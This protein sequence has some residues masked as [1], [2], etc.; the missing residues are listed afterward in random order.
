MSPIILIVVFLFLLIFGS[1]AAII[2]INSKKNSDGNVSGSVSGI[3]GHTAEAQSFL[4]F[5]CIQDNMIILPNQKFRMVLDCTSINYNL[6]TPAE[7]DQIELSFQRFLNTVACPITMFLQTKTI[8]NRERLELLDKNIEE[9]VSLYPGVKNYAEHYRQDMEH[10]N[11]R[12]GNSHQKKRY[13]IV[14]YDDV[15]MLDSLSPDEQENYAKK[16]LLNLSNTL[17]SNLEGVGVHSRILSTN[18]LY[19]LIYSCYY[20]DDYSYA[21]SLANQDACAL[22]VDGAEDQFKKMSKDQL[23]DLL[24]GELKNKITLENLDQTERGAQMLVYLDQ[25]KEEAYE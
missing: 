2:L 5:D 16:E 1:L 15:S 7:R 14:T 20:R 9:A 12:I 18:E 17:M 23:L 11:T 13:I 25:M 10:L 8:D 6:K 21:S 24:F 4:P 22:F 3:E 19:E